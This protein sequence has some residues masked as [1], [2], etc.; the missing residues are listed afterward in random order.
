[1]AA[2]SSEVIPENTSSLVLKNIR[3]IENSDLE[4]FGVI[5]KQ[6]IVVTFEH[7][8]LVQSIY[9]F[10]EPPHDEPGHECVFNVAIEHKTTKDAWL[11]HSTHYYPYQSVLSDNEKLVVF[12]FRDCVPTVQL[13]E[14]VNNN[15]LELG[16]DDLQT[17][18]TFVYGMLNDNELAWYATLT[19]K[20]DFEKAVKIFSWVTSSHYC[21]PVACRLEELSRTDEAIT[22]FK[23]VP[24]SR[25]ASNDPYPHLIRLAPLNTLDDKINFFRLVLEWGRNNIDQLND[26][27]LQNVLEPI[28]K[29][30]LLSMLDSNDNDP[31]VLLH[32][33]KFFLRQGCQ[34]LVEKLCKKIDSIGNTLRTDFEGAYTN[35]SIKMSRL[36]HSD[37]KTA[38]EFYLFLA[39]YYRDTKVL[40]TK[41]KVFVFN[42]YCSNAS[43]YIP[44]SGDALLT[45]QMTASLAARSPRDFLFFNE[46]P[47]SDSAVLFNAARVFETQQQLV[48]AYCLLEFVKPDKHAHGD[49]YSRLVADKQAGLRDKMGIKVHDIARMMAIIKQIFML[50]K[51]CEITDED[52]QETPDALLELFIERDELKS[53]LDNIDKKIAEFAKRDNSRALSSSTSGAFFARREPSQASSSTKDN[54]REAPVMM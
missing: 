6:G 13:L 28:D 50:D 4:Q 24:P 40:N 18:L 27:F 33:A 5:D 42:K 48:I 47:T 51:I 20:L 22:L 39:Q 44:Y 8:A 26:V 2:S 23:K 43:K 36:F 46:L 9:I 21:F 53:R 38:S 34:E 25:H 3:P 15:I 37:K 7:S 30:E 52:L 35:W 14:L 31:K 45:E 10:R 1:M 17:V 49:Y 41:T 32:L 19:E 12:T 16:E 54:Q 11:A 29:D